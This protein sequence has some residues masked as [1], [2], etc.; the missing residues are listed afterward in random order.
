MFILIGTPVKLLGAWK[1]ENLTLFRFL[2][3]IMVVRYEFVILSE[4]T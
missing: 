2:W 4:I 3:R 1:D